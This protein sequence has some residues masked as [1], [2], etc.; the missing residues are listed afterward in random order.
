MA[1]TPEGVTAIG[2]ARLLLTRPD[3][4]TDEYRCLPDQF[5][6]VIAMGDLDIDSDRVWQGS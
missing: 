3:N 5:T 6:E 2:L 1:V 4:L